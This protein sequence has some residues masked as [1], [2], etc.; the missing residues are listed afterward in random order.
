MG[1]VKRQVFDSATATVSSN[2]I[3]RHHCREGL[4]DT[5]LLLSLIFEIPAPDQPRV[6]GD[7]K[8]ESGV[9]DFSLPS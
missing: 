4:I 6:Y 2:S 7:L 3:M 9:T 8:G 5:R 1:L